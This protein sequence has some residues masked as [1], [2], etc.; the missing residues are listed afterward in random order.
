MKA[1]AFIGKCL[2]YGVDEKAL[3]EAGFVPT[4]QSIAGS[5]YVPTNTI[6]LNNL[7]EA[8][9]YLTM[10]YLFHAYSS[11]LVDP[12]LKP[13]H[14]YPRLWFVASLCKITKYVTPYAMIGI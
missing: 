4:V 12:L 10:S 7:S 14:T 11:R 3:M 2:H 6:L 9:T 5:Q 1:L 13:L 8:G